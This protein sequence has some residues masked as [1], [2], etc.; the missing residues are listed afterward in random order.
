TRDARLPTPLSPVV[1]PPTTPRS[2]RCRHTHPEA[3]H[4]RTLRAAA[5]VLP[6]GH[7]RAQA[8]APSGLSLERFSRESL[9][10]PP[11]LLPTPGGSAAAPSRSVTSSEPTS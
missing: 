2:S 10:G 6:I 7:G 3:A 9:R 1:T 5:S 8:L 4:S 11:G